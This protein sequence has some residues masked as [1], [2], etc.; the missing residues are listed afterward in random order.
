MITH[1]S[2]LHHLRQTRNVRSSVTYMRAV[3]QFGTEI[4]EE[5]KNPIRVRCV[6]VTSCQNTG[7]LSHVVRLD[8]SKDMASLVRPTITFR[9]R[10]TLHLAGLELEVVHAPGETE[11]QVI[12]WYPERRTLFPADNIYKAFPN[13]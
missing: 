8:K 9:D 12:V 1:E 4:P 2:F 5:T 3:R 6:M 7:L 10:L 11:D 13:L